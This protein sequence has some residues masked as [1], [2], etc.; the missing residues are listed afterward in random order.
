MH[1]TSE[2][3]CDYTSSV[4]NKL[5][6]AIAVNNDNTILAVA[7]SDN[8][9]TLYN[10]SIDNNSISCVERETFDLGYT[11]ISTRGTLAFDVADNL[12]MVNTLIRL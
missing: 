6:F 3:K 4:V 11:E 1:I 9:V 10:L 2:G 5:A 7:T 8:K 12:Y